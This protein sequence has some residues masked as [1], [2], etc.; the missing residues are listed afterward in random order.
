MSC[1]VV[2]LRPEADFLKLGVTPPETLSIRYLSP[3]APE[4][5]DAFAGARA[6]LIPAV[7]PK[8]PPD[9][10]AGTPIKLVQVTGAGIDRVDAAAMQALDIA[11]ANVPGGSSAA[12]A[13]YAVSGALGLLRRTAWADRE[14]RKGNYAAARS[15]MLAENL[16][17]LEGLTVG[18]VGLGIIGLAVAKA[19]HDL[20]SEIVYHDPAVRD[21]K[22]AE[23]LGARALPLAE[24]LQ[25][26]D[27]IT[28]HV[29]LL[30]STQSLIAD[31]E[32]AQMKAGAILI[33]AARGGVVDEAALA[34]SLSS[35]HLAGAA[36]DVFSSEPPAADNPLFMLEAEAAER[37]LLT[38]HIAGVTR[39][40]WEF[41]FRSAWQNVEAVLL[42]GE[43]PANRVF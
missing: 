41:L 25:T 22:P 30:P 31:A 12:I 20:R 17:G 10:F 13:E 33:N 2:C 23:A 11:V 24:L 35:G 3:D 19:F 7:G 5:R 38:P 6:V 34:R 9:L 42:R 18:V 4:L 1:D 29:P 37:L 26:S 43:P 15:R 8:L 32:F 40:S 28:L 14:L 36:V 27:V 21:P 39:Q 16:R